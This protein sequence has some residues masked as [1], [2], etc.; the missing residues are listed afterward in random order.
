MVALD[1]VD[2]D[3]AAGEV[4]AVM[5]PSGCGKSTLLRVVAGLQ[6][7]DAG[8]VS[9]DGTD[10]TATPPHRRGFGLMFQDFALFPHRDVARNVAFGLEMAGMPQDRIDARVAEMLEVVGLDGYGDRRVTVLSGGEQQ[11]VALARTLAPRPR[12]VM[13]DEPVA[14]LDRA[15][16]ERLVVEMRSIFARLGVTALYVTHDREEAFEI[17][18]RVAVMRTGTIV[19]EGAPRQLWTDPGSAF[20]AGFLGHDNVV[21]ATAAGGT[22][23][24]GG[25]AVPTTLDAGSRLVMVPAEAVTLRDGGDAEVISSVFRGGTNRVEVRSGDVALVTHTPDPLS[26]G[27][28]VAVHI[29]PGAVRTLRDG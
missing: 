18:D 6:A 24:I 7:P 20:V 8:W 10:L 17:S 9:W 3:V 1:G 21:L 26:P 14:S 4:V 22:L 13:L 15:L 2:L 16:R 19:A 11:R 23:R 28:R 12:L 5:G 25:V 29:D 27:D